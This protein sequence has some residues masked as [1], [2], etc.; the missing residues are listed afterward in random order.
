MNKLLSILAIGA[1][2][3]CGDNLKAPTDSHTIDTPVTIDTPMGFPAAPTLGAQIDRLGRPAVNTVLDH[4]FDSMASRAHAA[5]DA[6]NQ[7]GAVGTWQAMYRVEFAGNLAILDA[8]DKGLTCT[9]GTCTASATAGGCGNQ[10]LYDAVGGG[11]AASPASYIGLA[12]AL[13]DDQLYLD[14]RKTVANIPTSN[15]NYL[16]VELD[17]FEMIPNQTCG[18]RAPDNDVIDTSYSALAIGLQGFKLPNFLAFF[19]DGV[20]PHAD[21][22][23]Q[24]FPFLG[25]PH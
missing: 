18:G 2:A 10:V 16:A 12:A 21:V 17:A 24:T 19:G 23:D 14:T 13:A 9:A 20:G 11:S 15:Q 3:S 7:D 25:A 8:L 4:G 1:L 22:S 5:K 6:Y